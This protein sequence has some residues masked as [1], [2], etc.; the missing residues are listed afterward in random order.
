MTSELKAISL[1]KSIRIPCDMKSG[2]AKPTFD[3]LYI[4][5][6]ENSLK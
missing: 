1:K 2:I 6:I 3:P 5:S 4:M